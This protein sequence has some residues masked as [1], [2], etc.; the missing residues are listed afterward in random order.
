MTDENMLLRD[1]ELNPVRDCFWIKPRCELNRLV[2]HAAPRRDTLLLYELQHRQ[3]NRRFTKSCSYATVH[4]IR[5]CYY[6]AWVHIL[7]I[8]VPATK[9][10]MLDPPSRR[11]TW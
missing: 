4:T 1:R 8:L 6:C 3:E 2:L 9:M 5:C 10:L 7:S 11:G